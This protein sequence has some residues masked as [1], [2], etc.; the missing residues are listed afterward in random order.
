MSV[1]TARPTLHLAL[2]LNSIG[3][4]NAVHDPDHSGERV[5]PLRRFRVPAVARAFRILERLAEA[6]EALGVSELSREVGLAKST[7]FNLLLTLEELG[8][9][10]RVGA[11]TSFRLSY[12]LFAL[13]SSVAERSEMLRLLAPLIDELV[14]T[15]G[16]TAN[17]GIRQGDE[18][19]YLASVRGPGPVT[20]VES[21]G[22]R[23]PMH[24]TALGK[25]L[26]AWLPPGEVTALLAR[27]GMP[28]FTP[29][30]CDS[31]DQF[32]AELTTVT[33]LGY[34]VDNEENEPGMRCIGAPVFNRTG[35]VEAAISITAPVQRLALD[36]VAVV[37]TT[38]IRIAQ[39][40]SERLGYVAEPP[41]AI[42]S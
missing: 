35:H 2:R 36:G 10:Y 29:R 7:T 41:A 6:P 42:S 38:V 18:A 33:G 23:I 12:K 27:R 20:V 28:K 32:L 21:P 19:L 34:A 5:L 15:T 37:A 40:M 4:M 30:T 26:C 22:V 16:E 31:I 11:A 1:P 3:S 9:V 24:S 25:V 17:L 14:A 39:R 13:G 8:Y